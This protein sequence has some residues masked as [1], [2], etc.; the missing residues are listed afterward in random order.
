MVAA[1]A[2]STAV[3][4]YNYAV[5]SGMIPDYVGQALKNVSF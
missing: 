3:A 5:Y 1:A 2:V 4:G